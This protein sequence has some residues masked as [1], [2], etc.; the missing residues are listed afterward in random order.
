[1][2]QNGRENPSNPALPKKKNSLAYLQSCSYLNSEPCGIRPPTLD[3]LSR[4]SG[5]GFSLNL[6]PAGLPVLSLR[7]R[8]AQTGR[9]NPSNPALPKKRTASPICKAVLI[10]FILSRAGFEPSTTALK[11]RCSAY[12]ANGPIFQHDKKLRFH[13]L[14]IFR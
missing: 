14:E 3:V 10:F 2:S 7:L 4:V 9:E 8:L 12:W 6:P 1:M 11:G 13:L 5:P